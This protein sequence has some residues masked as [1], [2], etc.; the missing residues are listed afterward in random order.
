MGCVF[1]MT[2][3]DAGEQIPLSAIGMLTEKIFTDVLKYKYREQ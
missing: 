3:K 2:V 1:L